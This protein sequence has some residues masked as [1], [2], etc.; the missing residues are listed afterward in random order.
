MA[1]PSAAKRPRGRPRK[2]LADAPGATAQAL[3]K[4]LSLLALLANTERAT[5]TEI[6]LSAGMPASTAHRLLTTMQR[7]GFVEFDETAQ[8]WMVGLE[9]FRIGSAYLQRTNLVEAA[10]ETM[11]ALMEETGETANL[12]IAD[13]GQVVFVSQVETHNPIRA[14]FRPGTRGDL[15]ASGIGKA[16]LAEMPRD[17]AEETLERRGLPSYTGKTLT[18][19][20]A[21]F[22]DLEAARA[23]GWTLDDEERYSGMRCIA[24]PIFNEHGEAI[25]GISVSGPTVRLP[26]AL[27]AEI[28]AKV[29]RAADIVTDRVGGRRGD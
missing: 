12:G 24:A 19:P 4:G 6:A 11:R 9:A 20:A 14:F 13:A 21:L 16:L 25:A 26:D 3:D 15:H 5:L 2:D 23:R 28:G 27:V 1:N 8:D 29:R 7:H 18:Q 17:Q 22:G 10:R